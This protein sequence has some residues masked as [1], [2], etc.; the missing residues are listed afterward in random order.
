MTRTRT[1]PLPNAV[2]ALAMFAIV[3]P[4]ACFVFG[5]GASFSLPGGTPPDESAR[6]ATRAWFIAGTISA[7]LAIGLAVSSAIAGRGVAVRVVSV[8]AIL[9]ALMTGGLLGFL[10]LSEARGHVDSTPDHVEPVVPCGPESNPIVFGGDSR[11]Q[12]CPDDI[13]TA[14]DFLDAAVPK[15]PLEDVTAASVDS[16]AS[17]I[18]PDTYDGTHEYDNGDITVAWYPAPVTCAMATWRDGAWTPEVVGLLADGGC[19]YRGG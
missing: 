5:L 9:I 16:V 17:G 15:L 10:L 6:D 13:A 2:A 12:A 19:I 4:V 1:W 3:I 7:L 14:S 18:N 11:Y 8:I